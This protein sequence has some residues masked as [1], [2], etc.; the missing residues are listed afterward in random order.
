MIS[1]VPGLKAATIPVF[2]IVATVGFDDT[3][4]IVPSGVADPVKLEP[5]PTQA[6]SVPVIVGFGF[7]VTVTVN[8]FVQVFGV[9]PEVAVTAYVAVAEALVVFVNN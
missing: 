8:V 1:V 7:T 3:H 4:G 2:E 9:E 5:S 6:L